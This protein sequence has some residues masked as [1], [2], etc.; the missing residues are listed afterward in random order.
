MKN[1]TTALCIL[2]GLLT[3]VQ[4]NAQTI[5]TFNS[6]QPSAQTENLVL[7]STHTF[8]RIIRSGAT[9]SSGET[10]GDNLD[11]TGYVPIGGSST[12]GYLSISS[13]S[14]VAGCA[15]LSIS[16]NSGT[17]LWNVTSGGNVPFPFADLGTVRAF[18]AGT[19]TPNNHVMVCEETIFSG[20][21]NGDGYNDDGWI[22][23]IDPSTRTVINQDGVGGV[24]KLWA[25]GR[26]QHEDIA[27]KADGSVAYWSADNT[28]AG[29]VYKFV[30]AVAGNFSDGSLYVLQTTAAL[31]TGTWVPVANSTVND[32]N[33][34]VSLSSAAGAYNFNRVEGIEIGPDGKIYFPSTTSGNIYRFRDLGTTV[35]QLEIFVAPTAY[36]VDGAGPYPPEPWGVGADNIA[37]DGEGNL[38]VLQDGDRNYIWVVGPN[39]TAA[40]PNVRLFATTPIGSEPTGI[41]FSPDYKYLF[42]SIQHPSNTNTTPQTDAAGNSVTFDTH[43]TIVIARKENLGLQVVLPLKFL[44]FSLQQKNQSVQLAWIISSDETHDYF[45]VERSTDGVYFNA[46]VR[47]AG[48][49]TKFTAVDE[50]LPF[51]ETLYYRLKQHSKNGSIS[52]SEIKSIRP[53]FQPALIRVYPVPARNYLSIT[54]RSLTAATIKL[55]V[56]NA[57]GVVVEQK[58][59]VVSK[60]TNQLEL[61]TASLP[62]GNYILRIEDGKMYSTIDF[63]K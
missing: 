17:K 12:N 3:A 24:D 44:S 61:N 45:E 27:I 33:N 34:T 43:T 23:E 39:H 32:R 26:H 54:Y 53:V 58:E 11:F 38:W 10:L 22:I 30:P 7:P 29:Y 18:C 50:N 21:G 63:V 28:A 16:F 51:A 46:I 40:N 9:L 59:A 13:E 20:D 2:A 14:V 19:V 5:G 36:D 49:G 62:A 1:K 55:K 42:L 31:G 25:L 48:R 37:F 4:T 8:Q 52:Y 15:I 60:G 56:I 6:V 57:V 47:D 35:D 41:T